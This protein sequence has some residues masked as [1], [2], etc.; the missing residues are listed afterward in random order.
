VKSTYEEAFWGN[1]KKPENANLLKIGNIKC[2]FNSFSYLEKI[3]EYKANSDGKYVLNM[4]INKSYFKDVMS[5]LR[6]YPNKLIDYSNKC[7]VYKFSSQESVSMANIQRVL[8]PDIPSILDAFGYYSN[9][10]GCFIFYVENFV[11]AGIEQ[12]AYRYDLPVAQFVNAVFE[13][14]VLLLR[15]KKP[16]CNFFLR[17]PL[18]FSRRLDVISHRFRYFHRTNIPLCDVK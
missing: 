18:A 4:Q 16:G 1:N 15:H 5:L 7:D 10:S 14:A 6:I 9:E 13:T 3:D 2:R 17:V 12:F 11:R 8:Y